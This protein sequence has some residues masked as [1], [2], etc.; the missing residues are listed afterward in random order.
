MSG[1]DTSCHY[2]LIVVASDDADDHHDDG[3]NNKAVIP[4]L[5]MS[6]KSLSTGFKV[7]TYQHF[8][9]CVVTSQ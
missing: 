8:V 9:T 5:T 3:D 2:S 6:K 1:R 4:I 7:K